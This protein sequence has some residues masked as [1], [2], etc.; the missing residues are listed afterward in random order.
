M[1][2]HKQPLGEDTAHLA[3]R[4]DGTARLSLRFLAENLFFGLYPEF[5]GKKR[6]PHH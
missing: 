4:S 1:G 3:P 6:D 2:G 5:V